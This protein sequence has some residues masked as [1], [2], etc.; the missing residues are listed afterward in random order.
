MKLHNEELY[1]L[2]SS[3]KYYAH[4]I[5]KNGVGGTCGT[6]GRGAKSVEGFGGKVRRKETTWKTKA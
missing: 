6:H 5:K 3:Q 1:I 4:P 2:Y